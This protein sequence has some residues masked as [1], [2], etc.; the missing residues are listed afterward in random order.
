M[1]WVKKTILRLFFSI[2]V[3]IFLMVY[4]FGTNGIH[5]IISL[6]KEDQL[7]IGEI[8]DIQKEIAD[9]RQQ[10]ELWHE[11]PYYKEKIAREKLQMAKENEIIY[12]IPNG[13]SL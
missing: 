8:L 6:K 7:L 5:A 1:R 2:E 3:F 11:D 10:L 12:I 13:S 4:I 9:L